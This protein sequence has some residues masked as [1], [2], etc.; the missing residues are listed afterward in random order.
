MSAYEEPFG[1]S[2]T[3]S[4]TDRLADSGL[5]DAEILLGEAARIRPLAGQRGIAVGLGGYPMMV[6]LFGSTGALRRH[7]PAMLEAVLVDG[8]AAGGAGEPVPAR[9]V[10]RLVAHIESLTPTVD[11]SIDARIGESVRADSA[12]VALRCVQF[13]RR[14]AHISVFDRRHPVLALAC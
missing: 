12:K 1:A 13:E 3:S 6:E 4:Y 2:A 5:G 10:R 8:I 7:M 14:W 9:R 11:R